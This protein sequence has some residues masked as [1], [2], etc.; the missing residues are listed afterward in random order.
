[1]THL[2]TSK[3]RLILTEH[4]SPDIISFTKYEIS[5]Q[6]K[7]EAQISQLCAAVRTFQTF[8]MPKLVQRS[9]Q[10][11]PLDAFVALCTDLQFLGLFILRRFVNLVLVPYN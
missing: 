2:S 1:M 9:Q 7:L 6:I 5:L 11:L 8:F 10:K 4:A 3:L